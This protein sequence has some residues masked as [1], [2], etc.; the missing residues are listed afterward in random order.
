MKPS[1]ELYVNGQKVALEAECNQLPNG[2]V[3]H[4]TSSGRRRRFAIT[5]PDGSFSAKVVVFGESHLNVGVRSSSSS[6]TY[7]GLLGNLDGNAAN[8]ARLRTGEIISS[9]TSLESL[10]RFGGSW[11]VSSQESLFRSGQSVSFQSTVI[12]SLVER[13]DIE[14]AQLA[15]AQEVCEAA[16]VSDLLALNNCVFDVA[17]SGNNI[18]AQSARSFQ[19]ALQANSLTSSQFTAGYVAQVTGT[20]TSTTEVTETTSTTEVTETAQTSTEEVVLGT[21]DVQ[22]TL[23]WPTTDDLDLSVID[24]SGDGIDFNTRTIASGGELDVDSNAAC[25]NITASPVENVF[26]P[27][28]VAP[29]GDYLIEVN[30]YDLCGGGATEIPFE[31]VVT[32]GGEA[33]TFSGIVGS[34]SSTAGYLLSV[35]AGTGVVTP[36]AE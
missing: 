28:G 36:M 10:N 16:G 5:W 35:N 23:R 3:I 27:T 22:V 4:Q 14:S 18:F 21:G 13:S 17:V 33:Q 1:L 20:A 11:S 6:K 34:G 24:P 7:Q 9:L 31:L 2:G 25:Q 30:L 12:E 26:W 29:S 8:D 32:T 19:Q 15:R